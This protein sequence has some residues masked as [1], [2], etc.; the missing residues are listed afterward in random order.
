MIAAKKASSQSYGNHSLAIVTI[1]RCDFFDNGR[2]DKLK[3]LSKTVHI[4]IKKSEAIAAI[5][6]SHM[7]T[8]LHED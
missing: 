2:W 4:E 3:S 7:E 6:T 8:S 1:A 5:V